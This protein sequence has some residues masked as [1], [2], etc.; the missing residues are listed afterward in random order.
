MALVVSL[1]FHQLVVDVLRFPRRAVLIRA[2]NLVDYLYIC[3]TVSVFVVR[4]LLH[5]CSHMYTEL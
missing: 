1:I 4:V 2:V 5:N 3:I